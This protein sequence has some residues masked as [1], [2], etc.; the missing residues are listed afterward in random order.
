MDIYFAVTDYLVA[1]AVAVP[2]A[3]NNAVGDAI[4][5]EYVPYA[6]GNWYF[7]GTGERE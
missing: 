6:E 4:G 7:G 5:G 2:G 1:S 3:V